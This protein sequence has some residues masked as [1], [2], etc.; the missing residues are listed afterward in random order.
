MADL[1]SLLPLFPLLPPSCIPQKVGTNEM[2]RRRRRRKG[3]LGHFTYVPAHTPC[4]TIP[5]KEP[6]VSR[7]GEMVYRYCKVLVPPSAINIKVEMKI[8]LYVTCA[9]SSQICTLPFLLLNFVPSSLTL[10]GGGGG[11]HLPFPPNQTP[12]F[13]GTSFPPFPVYVRIPTQQQKQ[14]EIEK[15]I[16][17]A[18]PSPLTYFR[19]LTSTP[20]PPK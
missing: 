2:R 18:L 17:D 12:Y 7:G 5:N 20:P 19:L 14:E 3:S 8:L 15:R 13:F 11:P 1:P 4:R 16:A 10:S 6:R 9:T